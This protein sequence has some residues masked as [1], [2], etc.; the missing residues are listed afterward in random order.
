MNCQAPAY[1]SPVAVPPEGKSLTVSPL[2]V[3]LV[4]G[5]CFLSDFSNFMSFFSCAVDKWHFVWETAGFM[6]GERVLGSK[7][8]NKKKSK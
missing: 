5:W 8:M 3:T 1:G 6:L 4:S 2:S 7:N